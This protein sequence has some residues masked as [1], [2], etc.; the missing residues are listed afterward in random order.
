MKKFFFIVLIVIVL[1]LG[2]V[3]YYFY[4]KYQ[5]LNTIIN[6]PNKAAQ[7]DINQTLNKIG[8]FML[9]PT[10][11]QPTLATVVDASKL[12]TQPF[13][14]NAQNGDRV[15]LYVNAKL[16]ILY[17]P[18]DNKIINVGPLLIQNPSPTPTPEKNVKTPSKTPTKEV[19]PTV[20]IS[21]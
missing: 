10:K 13:F 21:P 4:S 20:K 2:G 12:K 5:N 3:T 6:N 9:L 16:A 7:E 17:R 8:K 15:I 1:A 19:S 18:G 14:A 11:E